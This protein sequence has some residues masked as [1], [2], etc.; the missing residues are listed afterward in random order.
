MTAQR[1]PLV[2][3]LLAGVLSPITLVAAPDTPARVEVSLVRTAATNPPIGAN[4]FG[5]PGGTQFSA[6]NLIPDSGFEP[7]SMRRRVRVSR[8]GTENGHPW[9]EF[10]ENGG[11]TSW[12]LTTSGLYNGAAVRI[13]RIVDANGQPLPQGSDNYLDLTNAAAYTLVGSSTIPEAGAADLPLGGWVDSAYAMPSSVYGTRTNLDYTDARW[14][15]NGKTY[16][17]IVTAIG[18]N[19]A[20]DGGANESDPT[21]AL[22]LTAAP[23]AGLPSAPHIYVASG[24][25]LNEIGNVA[26]DN[27]Y[28]FQPR[29]A[30]ATGPVTWALLDASN[31]PIT[32]PGGLTFDPATGEL[33]GQATSTPPPTLLRFRA[34]AANG[35]ATRDF[36]LNNPDWT[37]TGGTTR[38]LPPTN[39]VATAA[40]GYVHLSWTASATPDVVGYRVYRAEVPRAQQRQR[41]YLAPGAPALVRDDYVHLEKRI[42]TANP[43]W[44]HPRVRT[45]TVGEPWRTGSSA[46]TLRRV[47]HP[48]TIPADFLFPGD[49]CLQVTAAAS[50]TDEIS[51]PAIFFPAIVHGEAQWYS[52]LEPGR[53]Y[54]YEAWLRQSGL[55][56]SG[57][58]TLTISGAYS[59]IAQTFAVDST[60]RL[61]TFEFTAPARPTTSWHMWPVVRFTGP[62]QLWVDNIRLFR[63]DTPADRTATLAPPSPLVYD[64]LMASQ[65]LTGEKGMLRSMSVLLNK[66]TMA[67]CLGLNRDAGLTM[68]WYQAAEGAGN[69]TVPY[70]LQYALRSGDSPASRLKPWLNISSNMREDEWLALVEYL[71][72]TIN[73]A[74]P[75]DV[76]A[77]PWAYLRYRQRGVTTPWTDEFTRIYFEFANETWHNGAVS[78]EWFGWGRSGWVHS[79][80]REFGLAADYLTTY[81]RSHSPYFTALDAAGKLRF[82][83]GSNYVDYGELAA[84]GAPLTHAIGHTTY[85]GPKWEVGETPLA[86]YD[87]HGIQATLLGHVADTAGSF[88][89]YR[90]YREQLAAAGHTMDLLAYEGGPSGYA[91]PGQDSPTQHDYSERYG[92]SIAMAVAALD[93]WL[94]AYETG[95]SDQ[96]YLGMGVGDYW[97]SHTQIA[98]GYRAHAG[99]LA[100]T[101][102]NRY[103]SGRLIRSTV[104][105][106]PTIPW[107]ATE[108]PLVSSYAFRDGKRLC[109][110]LLSRKLG[111]IH[112]G[113]DFGDGSTPVTL[114]LPA[115][116]TGPA[117][118]YHLSGDPRATNREALNVAIQQTTA[119]LGRETTVTLP[120]G[121]IYL[122][123]VDTDLPDRDDPPAEPSTTPAVA[124]TAGGTTLTW[125][126]VA[127]ADS[128]TVFR[129][130]KPY[131]DRSDVTE[132]SSVATNTFT[133]EAA[134]GGTTYYYRVAAHNAWGTGFWTLVAAGGT[135]PATPVLPAPS[136]DGLLE[137]T[138]TLVANWHE[139][140]DA[141]GYR[142]GLATRSGGPY[143]WTDAGIAT[144]WTF[145]GL[146]NGRT[147]FVAV[148]AYSPAGRSPDSAERSGTPLVAGQPAVIAAWDGAV[149]NYSANLATPPTI[150]PVARHQLAVKAGHITRGPGV[151]L[152]TNNYG[153]PAGQGGADDQ[154]GH[155]DG[156]FPFIPGDDGGNFGATGGGSLANAIAREL[157]IGATVTPGVGQSVALGELQAGFQYS[158]GA[159]PLSA[160]LRYR[161]GSGVWHELPVPSYSVATGA[162]VHNDFT[163]PLSGE[164]A[165]Q[166][167]TEPLELRLYLYWTGEDARWHPAALTRTTGEDLI[168]RG[169]ATTFAAPG[170]PTGLRSA[171]GRHQVALSWTPV[172]GATSYTVRW[173]TAPG[174]YT[175]SASGLVQATTVVGDLAGGVLH[176][177]TVEAV[178]AFGTGPTTAPLAVTPLTSFQSWQR[179]T[180]SDAQRDAGL[181]ATDA[182]PDADGATN[183][184]EYAFGTSPLSADQSPVQVALAGAPAAL[185]AMLP[186]RA[187]K[188][189]IVVTVE[190]SS[191][192]VAWTP[193][194][195]S[196]AGAPMV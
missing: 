50:G 61:C 10:D 52:Q 177:F 172:A 181:A 75:A 105:Q 171:A 160:V 123:V 114:S 93:A 4:E 12:E 180:F 57:Q 119:T 194:A 107:D 164:P 37:A 139:I 129:S 55:A 58:V 162:W 156:K 64:E 5:D 26:A 146:E 74:N 109:V 101:L 86:A 138:G 44:A 179:A 21:T 196:T 38:P 65:P 73:P 100:L 143:T 170:Q 95:F 166:T 6:G 24:N 46:T 151:L 9:F 116:P 174:V 71:G 25:G 54:R 163:L 187:E 79:G 176:Y 184:V 72:A 158:Y 102:R 45:G 186:L 56:D 182:D 41:V 142:V 96:A 59:A 92:K 189:D 178:N 90:R 135:N 66:A 70:F 31:N 131:F 110:F 84:A 113:I 173:G 35:T 18:S 117:T 133:D 97:S 112:D 99:W 69:M 118:L 77:K 141:T 39:I 23:Q 134:G 91:L 68:N 13:Y 98:D 126:A 28:G 104:V 128:Y 169:T 183:I 106:S 49:S 136:L 188:D 165:L 51:G 108:Y 120:Q 155:Y 127:G 111:G 82:V 76:A 94:A 145:G 185:T 8:T 7:I 1:L 152:D 48:G 150:L 175:G 124:H 149:L 115:N 20:D 140:P 47:A 67:S 60:W 40:D 168:L 125:P 2:A 122:Y 42:L 83:I 147:Y 161:L 53:T 157:Y 33:G 34:T 19:T 62:G 121:S 132:T 80:F 36:V 89:N 85:V 159:R 87:D 153:F 16:H 148:H 29:V 27:W 137:S 43:M 78:D 22:E 63:A 81:V 15:E 32:P 192:L 154:H 3:G 167:I 30:G 11:I 130:T 88:V 195:R 103:A 17:Y 14:V 193:L 190:A 191:D 144:G